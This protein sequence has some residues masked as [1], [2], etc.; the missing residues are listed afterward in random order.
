MRPGIKKPARGWFFK[1]LSK[2]DIFD[3]SFFVFNVF[4]NNR[5]VFFNNHFFGH[6][7]FILCGGVV[8]TGFGGRYQLNFVSHN[9]TPIFQRAL[10]QPI[11]LNMDIN[12]VSCVL[13]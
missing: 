7:T 1:I 6:S 11:Q 4:T 2:L 8:V 13:T 10:F 9:N 12:Y 3:F 5:I